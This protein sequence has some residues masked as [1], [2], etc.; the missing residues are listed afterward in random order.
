MANYD[1]TLRFFN[2]ELP[3]VQ[4]VTDNFAKAM[5]SILPVIGGGGYDPLLYGPTISVPGEV[6]VESLI[7][8]DDPDDLQAQL[9]EIR[10]LYQYGRR[11]LFKIPE[12]EDVTT[13]WVPARLIDI[14]L[15]QDFESST[16]MMI[17]PVTLVFSST[18]NYWVTN[19]NVGYDTNHGWL[20]ADPGKGTEAS[21]TSENTTASNVYTN[22][23]K[24][25]TYPIIS[26]TPTGTP[27]TITI[28]RT[29]GA[30]TVQQISF[31]NLA[32]GEELIIDCWTKQVTVDG[33]SDYD[34]FT[35]D[36]PGWIDFDPGANSLV[37]SV[38]A[39]I[40]FS[41]QVK[42]YELYKS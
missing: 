21:A 3:I 40:P 37:V 2:T 10:G 36:T 38:G 15:G 13:R 12:G 1:F 30:V 25:T 31:A 5:Y 16:G 26:I 14:Q 33:V 18:M 4:S 32:S 6:T 24:F 29:S 23:G 27:G 19:N 28:S 22:N 9:D 34:N 11:Y 7:V 39:S 41:L 17:V 20:T 8:V 35:W 42:W